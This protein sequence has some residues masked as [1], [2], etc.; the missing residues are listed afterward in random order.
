MNISYK[1]AA[2]PLLFLITNIAIAATDCTVQTDLPIAECQEL[3]RFWEST[4]GDMWTDADTNNWNVSNAPCQW[5][6]V[7]CTNGHVTRIT[8]ATE[9]SGRHIGFDLV[10]TVPEDLDLPELTTLSV[11][12]N[13]L[14]GTIPNFTHLPKLESLSLTTN[15]FTG[16]IPDFDNLPALKTLNLS[17]NQLTGQIPD[18]HFLPNLTSLSLQQNQLTGSLVDFSNLPKLSRLSVANNQLTGTIP[19]F[20]HLPELTRLI[21]SFNNF[22]GTLPNFNNL[23][24]LTQLYVPYTQLSGELP[25]LDK[26][27]KLTTFYAYNN[28]FSGN[29]PSFDKNAELTRL[30]VSN[31]QLTGTLPDFT[32][33]PKLS[34]IVLNNNK[35]TGELGDL[36]YLTELTTLFIA[37]NSIT[38][39]A[40]KLPASFTGHYNDFGYFIT[41]TP[42][43]STAATPR[44][45]DP[46]ISVLLSAL[47]TLL[48]D[49]NNLLDISLHSELS[50]ETT[51]DIYL[52]TLLPNGSE[53]LFISPTEGLTTQ[54]SALVTGAIMGEETD[55]HLLSI[56]IL[57]LPSGLYPIYQIITEQGKAPLDTTNWLSG[58]FNLLFF[59]I[60]TSE[61]SVTAFKH[62]LHGKK[63]YQDNCSGC[64]H[65]ETRNPQFLFEA[66]KSPRLIR[67]TFDDNVDNKSYLNFLSDADLQA[68]ADYVT[69]PYNPLATNTQ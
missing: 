44:G 68:I 27:P 11:G 7:T 49:E 4:E 60:N 54:P 16:T 22:T 25:T 35:L 40:I 53:L 21:I 39:Q 28:Q 2:V 18:F 61:S 30:N 52:A 8:R 67:K 20:Q 43:S 36:S 5:T 64:H 58:Q 59:A 34:H 29:L 55:Y 10:G 33:T 66:A 69:T 23:P 13:A 62:Y 57:G 3:V 19:D 37:G 56:P 24:K 9:V 50:Q 17:D 45:T 65:D 6:G 42:D 51:V 1:Y 63:L 12:Y 47:N 15:A 46:S 38:T 14:E 31:N 32:T 41:Q 48:D 26:L